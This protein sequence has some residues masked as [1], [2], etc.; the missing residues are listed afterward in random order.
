MRTRERRARLEQVNA[1]I[2]TE[3][4]RTPLPPGCCGCQECARHAGNLSALIKA[5]RSV[6]NDIEYLHP[7]QIA[8]L[9]AAIDR[10]EKP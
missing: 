8:N 9:K 6:V 3:R 2:A 5:A 7:Q 4:A 10:A 1:T